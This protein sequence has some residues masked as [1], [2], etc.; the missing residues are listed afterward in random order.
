MLCCVVL[1]CV[2]VWCGLF[3][4][5]YGLSVKLCCVVLWFVVLIV[6]CCIVLCCC[7]CISMVGSFVQTWI[8]SLTYFVLGIVNDNR[9]T[10]IKNLSDLNGT[11]PKN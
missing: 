8:Y 5:L 10:Y 2:V 11:G 1:C 6:L 3:C 9:E 4:Q 7:C